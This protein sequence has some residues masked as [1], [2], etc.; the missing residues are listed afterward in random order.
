MCAPARGSILLH[1]S[2]TTIVLVLDLDGVLDQPRGT[3]A[4]NG[5][6]REFH[7]WLGL[8]SVIETLANQTAGAKPPAADEGD[9]T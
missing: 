3:A 7:G 6:T 5:S 8:A 4:A 9:Q 1:V 2:T